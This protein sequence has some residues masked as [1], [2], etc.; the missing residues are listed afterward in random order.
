MLD[1]SLQKAQKAKAEILTISAL[2]VNSTVTGWL[3]ATKV[4]SRTASNRKSYLQ[5]TLRDQQGSEI[6]ARYFDIPRTD[7]FVLQE[8]KVVL[9]EG[10]VEEYYNQV[11]IKLLRAETDESVPIDL[12]TEGTRCPLAQ[13][14]ADFEHLIDKVYHRG[15]RKLL[16]HCFSSEVMDRFQR[17]P[18]AMRHHGAVVGGLLEHTVNVTHIAEQVARLYPCNA[19]LV[20]AG[21]LLHDIGKLEE[22]EERAGAGYTP[23]GH[24]VGHIVLGLQYVQE[25][26]GQIP[27]LDETTVDDLLHIILAH[28]TKELGSPVNPATIEALIVHQADATEAHITSFLEHCKRSPG[29][30]GWTAYSS[31][32]GGQL[33]MPS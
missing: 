6:T 3:F 33:R 9:V 15:L 26:A 8:G 10:V 17:W 32:H 18:A 30:N 12:F 31:I 24:M 2:Q 16:L 1:Q 27:E 21:A 22:L 11:Q 19:N 25:Q 7:T 28:H 13:L 20:I 14:E 29:S 23:A 5:L 4:L